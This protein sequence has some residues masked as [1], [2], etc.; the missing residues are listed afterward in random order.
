MCRSM[1][2]NA[3]LLVRVTQGMTKKSGRAY[4]P[5]RLETGIFGIMRYA[6]LYYKVSEDD[7]VD[8]KEHNT[9][10]RSRLTTVYF[11]FL[12]PLY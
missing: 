3:C 4:F 12:P 2:K 9:C 11:L 7:T 6:V 5:M 10:E 1:S 8:R